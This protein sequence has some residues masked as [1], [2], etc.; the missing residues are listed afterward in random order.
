VSDEF[1]RKMEEDLLRQYG[2]LGTSRPEKASYTPK[3]LTSQKR[4]FELGPTRA[5]VR[6]YGA[7]AL[8]Q[9]GEARAMFHHDAWRKLAESRGQEYEELLMQLFPGESLTAKMEPSFSEGFEHFE[10]GQV[11]YETRDEATERIRKEKG[12]FTH[13]ERAFGEEG[14][15][16]KPVA[17]SEG[18]RAR[19]MSM[20]EKESLARTR[21]G[22]PGPEQE[23][24]LRLRKTYNKA[25]STVNRQIGVLGE[26]LQ[27][28][29]P[30][31]EYFR[32]LTSEIGRLNNASGRLRAVAIGKGLLGV[33]GLVGAGLNA[34]GSYKAI[35]EYA[36]DPTDPD[37]RFKMY[38]DLLGVPPGITGRKLT[39]EEVPIT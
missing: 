26:E 36:K 1:E 37:R 27:G 8:G 22:P 23:R 19:R 7:I 12:K 11:R 34:A 33:A 4:Q 28:A 31:G 15:T 32:T 35:K 25:L 30:G 13:S 5:A 14:F 29:K 38:E 24:F 9:P 2:Y 20:P 18:E 6:D 17:I 21:R 10:K 3:Y 16:D 39:R